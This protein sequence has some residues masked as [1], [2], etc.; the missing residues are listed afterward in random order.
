M[1]IYM[2]LSYYPA[3]VLGGLA[4]CLVSG[5]VRFS[6][7]LY[8]PYR[9]T[10]SFGV[11]VS[12]RFAALLLNSSVSSGVFEG[13]LHR[14]SGKAMEKDSL[15]NKQMCNW[16]Q[17]GIPLPLRASVVD[18]QDAR[19]LDPS[20]HRISIPLTTQPTVFLFK[21]SPQYDSPVYL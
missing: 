20:S 18:G 9:V 7:S 21:S 4:C 15:T 8:V 10:R 19:V 17:Y 5:S 3:T 1:G 2:E 16:K 6:R 14:F 13:A 11:L 12:I